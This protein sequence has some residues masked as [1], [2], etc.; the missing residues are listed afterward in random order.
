VDTPVID[1]L[2]IGLHSRGRRLIELRMQ[3]AELDARIHTLCM[4]RPFDELLVRRLKKEKLV[5]KD[6]IAQ[7]EA[8]LEPPES[9]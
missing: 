2:T 3:H 7:M 9:A 5:L 4:Q 8:E 6:L 1:N